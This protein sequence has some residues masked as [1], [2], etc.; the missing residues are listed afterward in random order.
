MKE[1]KRREFLKKESGRDM[2][3]RGHSGNM[4]SVFRTIDGQ[5]SGPLAARPDAGE[6]RP[7][8]SVDQHGSRRG[9]QSQ[10]HPDGL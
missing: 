8:D 7:H 10:S 9:Q 2:R 4:E 3:R 5:G 1:N 6:N